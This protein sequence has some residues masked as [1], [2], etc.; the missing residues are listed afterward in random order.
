LAVR[1]AQRLRTSTSIG[2]GDARVG[3]LAHLRKL[4][5]LKIHQRQYRPWQT[6]SRGIGGVHASGF[7]REGRQDFDEFGSLAD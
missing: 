4:R 2:A 6:F 3:A 7:Q 5:Y 1:G